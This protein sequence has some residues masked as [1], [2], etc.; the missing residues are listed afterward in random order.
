MKKPLIFVGSRKMM[1]ELACIAELN[2]IEILGILD[3]HYPDQTIAGIPVLGDERWLLD[4][5]NAQAQQWLKTCDFFPANWHNG[6]Q[7]RAGQISLPD[8]RLERIRILDES[9]ASVINLI[10]PDAC[11]K[12]LTSRYANYRIGR[13]IQIHA[14]V[15]HSVDNIEIGD[16]CAFMS[17]NTCAHDVRI[18]RNVLVA[19]ETYLYDCNIGDNGYV[20]IYSRMNPVKKRGVIDIGKNVTIWINADVTRDVPDDCFY[21]TDG[22]VMSKFKEK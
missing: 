3:H 4:P 6:E 9:R 12:G 17:G 20:G 21:T 18:G 1:R 2:D 5:N 11:I 22:R 14:N 19:P 15:Y 7:H 16:Y 13:G 8:L 10:H